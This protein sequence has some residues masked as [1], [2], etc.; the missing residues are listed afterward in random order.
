VLPARLDD[1]LAANVVRVPAGLA[2]TATLGAL[3]GAIT[4]EKA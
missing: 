3:F 1:T 2:Q 4:V